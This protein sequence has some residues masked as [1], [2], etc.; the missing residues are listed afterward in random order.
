[1]FLVP[2]D[3][4]GEIHCNVF[5]NLPFYWMALSNNIYCILKSHLVKTLMKEHFQNGFTKWHEQ[6]AKCVQNKGKH[7]EGESR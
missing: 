2:V 3:R 7:F 4:A 5:I 1:M 6:W